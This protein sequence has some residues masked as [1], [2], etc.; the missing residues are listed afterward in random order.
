MKTMMCPVS[1]TSAHSFNSACSTYRAVRST[2]FV[3]S[4]NRSIFGRYDLA[5]AS[6]TAD[7]DSPNTS[8]TQPNSSTVGS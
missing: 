8:A 5:V 4:P 3:W 6:S 2:I 1:T 7:S